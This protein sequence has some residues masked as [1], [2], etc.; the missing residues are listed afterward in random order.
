MEVSK[1]KI[2]TQAVTISTPVKMNVFDGKP[3]GFSE[4]VGFKRETTKVAS[5][6]WTPE[7]DWIGDKTGIARF[8]AKKATQTAVLKKTGVDIL[9]SGDYQPILKLCVDNGW[10]PASALQKKVT[11]KNINGTFHINR[12]FLLKDLANELRTLHRGTV[13]YTPELKFGIPAV[14]FKV[15]D[16][17]WTYQFFENGTVLFA[18]IKDPSMI[19]EPQKLFKEFFEIIPPVFVMTTNKPTE[20]SSKLASR[21]R[22]AG[23][24][25]ALI[26]PPKGFYIRPGTNGKPRLY[27]WR[28]MKQNPQTKEWLNHGALNLTAVV[29]KVIKA[30]KNAG[31]PIP[32]TTTNA[33]QKAGYPL[34]AAAAKKNSRRAPSWNAVKP[35]YYVRPGPG[36]HPYWYKEPKGKATVK[37]TV[38]A[39]YKAAGRD[40]PA[41]VR[42]MFAI[43]EVVVVLAPAPAPPAAAAPSN[44]RA[45]SWNAVKPGYYVKPGPGQQPYWFKEPKG[46]V[47]AKKTVIAAYKAA[48]RNIPEAVRK[49]F[50]ITEVLLVNKK[51]HN[52]TMGI[53]G[54]IRI[55]GQQASRFTKAQL[56][57]IA[58]N[59]NIPQANKSLK[60]IDLV[61]LI[62]VKAGV[63][64]QGNMTYNVKVND[65]Y[66]KFLNNGRVEKTKSNKQGFAKRTVG[67]WTTFKNKNKVAK[68]YLPANKYPGYKYSTILNHKKSLIKSPSSNL[69]NFAANLE[70][71]ML[72]QAYKNKYKAIKNLL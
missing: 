71:E 12:T 31:H 17:K 48:G 70:A 67:K 46:K 30:F 18:G 64:G 24:W 55:N 28:N 19:D 33:F 8:I 54:M 11:Y 52:V 59:M 20:K 53:N 41:A 25:N 40:I 38:V 16:P 3:V 69:S 15:K 39:A 66:Y 4:V 47:A 68:V 44:R 14:V 27:R 45:P 22:L 49:I 65:V 72:N 5:L 23:T 9:G 7:T 56:I 58:R 63:K 57:A 26:A 1:S 10:I 35:G 43:N 29:P 21:Y 61:R 34:V 42:K 50:G 2:S 6:R 62:Q 32:K 37:K 13:T 51:T 36:Q 60:P